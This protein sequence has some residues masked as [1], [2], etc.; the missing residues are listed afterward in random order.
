MDAKTQEAASKTIQQA[1][2]LTLSVADQE[3]FA[4]ALLSPPK[5]NAALKRAFKRRTKIIAF[6]PM[7]TARDL[8]NLK[9]LG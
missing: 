5:P 8:V 6:L 9:N 7:A 3:C 1:D 4:K 2:I